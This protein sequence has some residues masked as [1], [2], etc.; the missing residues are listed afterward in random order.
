MS[1]TVFIAGASRGLGLEFARQYSMRGWSV[2]AGV[3]QPASALGLLRVKGVEVVPLD[4]TSASSIA[5][6]AWLADESPLQRLIINAGVYGPETGTFLAPGDDEFDKVMHTNVLGPMRL[7]QVFGDSVARAGGTIAVLSSRMGSIDDC[8]SAGA[9]TYRA[10]KAAVN[11]VV[12]CAAQE[13][14]PKGA[15]V[16]SLHPGWVKTD[17]GGPNALIDPFESVAGLYKVIEAAQPSDN[18]KF[19]NYLGEA[20]PW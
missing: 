9:M 14:G 16:I 12:K 5:G 6:A 13:Y 7:I 10:S 2:V 17:M 1:K 11:M 4:V 19:L 18:G 15:T 8:G 20:L 3:R